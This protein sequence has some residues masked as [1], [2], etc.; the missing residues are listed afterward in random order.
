MTEPEEP[1]FLT[2]WSRRKRAEA[3]PA[4]PP[5]EPESP[6]AAQVETAPGCPIPNGPTVDL[7]SLPRIEDLTTASDLGPFLRPGVP[8]ALR[9]AALRRMWSLDTAIRDYIGPV[10]YQ[11]DFNAPGGLPLGFSNELVG[12][13]AKLLEQAIGA[14][15][16]EARPVAETPL[17]EP[18]DPEAEP[19]I[20]PPIVQAALPMPAPAPAPAQEP[21][22]A[23]VRRHGR[24]LPQARA[25]CPPEGQ[26]LA[27]DGDLRSFNV[28]EA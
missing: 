4:P 5:A 23:P 11:W 21:A 27:S 16:P 24:A 6:P 9:D 12:D 19:A 26:A 7:A 17:V 20:E 10:E 25:E 28:N 13:I 22:L 1:G 3:E 2:R 15:P 18:A 8:G 14:T